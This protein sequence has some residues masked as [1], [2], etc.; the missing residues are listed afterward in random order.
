MEVVPKN[1]CGILENSH[2]GSDDRLVALDDRFWPSLGNAEKLAE[3]D[4]PSESP[5]LLLVGEAM[6]RLCAQDAKSALRTPLLYTLTRLTALDVDCRVV[7]VGNG[8]SELGADVPAFDGLLVAIVEVNRD[9]VVR[10][11]VRVA[12]REEKHVPADVHPGQRPLLLPATSTKPRNRARKDRGAY[13]LCPPQENSGLSAFLSI[14][15]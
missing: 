4:E 12:H 13:H 5:V 8:E 10:L 6:V 7:G 9:H 15:R 14:R 11:T 3:L 2:E 1:A